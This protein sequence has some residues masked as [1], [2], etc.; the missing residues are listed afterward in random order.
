MHEPVHPR[1]VVRQTYVVYEREH[2]RRHDV[3]IRHADAV[4]VQLCRRL[5]HER[6]A[7]DVEHP[8]ASHRLD[9]RISQKVHRVPN[10]NLNHEEDVDDRLATR[11]AAPGA[12][13]R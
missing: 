8:R 1:R 4:E 2:A 5:A 12:D 10:D 9:R 11:R 6:I 3:V 7:H 13:D